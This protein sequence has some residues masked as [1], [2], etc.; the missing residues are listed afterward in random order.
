MEVILIDDVPSLGKIGEL[1]KVREGYARNFLLPRSLAIPA[2]T[3][4]KR[5]LEH[6]KRLAGFRLA[7]ARAAAE[8]LKQRLENVAV[9]IARRVGEQDKMFGS[10]TSRD[11]HEA[12]VASGVEIDRRQVHMHDPIKALG[13]Y[14]VPA[15]LSGGVDAMINVNVVAE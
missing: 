2:S 12:L 15:R 11:I 3:K 14:K 13:S 8:S 4:N 7:K 1:L 9:T 5:R 10:V 6:E